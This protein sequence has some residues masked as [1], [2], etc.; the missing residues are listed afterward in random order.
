MNIL[1]KARY[2]ADDLLAL[3]DEKNFEL[4]DGVLVERPMG[5]ESSWIGGEIFGRI[6]DLCGS[7]GVGWVWPADNGIQCFSGSEY[8]VRKPDVM[9]VRKERLNR[10]PR[11]Y[12]RIPPDLVVEVVS[13]HDIAEEV[14]RKVEEYRTAGVRLVWVVWPGNRLID[15]YTPDG[16]SVR[17]GENDALSGNDVVP[18]FRCKVSEVFPPLEAVEPYVPP[19]SDE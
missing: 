13:P 8:K 19:P 11:G 6:R 5:S 1:A 15:V 12:L 7:Q 14:R 17:L 18:G 2:T 16:T 9:F 3:P 4:V 10:M